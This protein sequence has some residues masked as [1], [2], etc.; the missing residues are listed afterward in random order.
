M[1]GL[2]TTEEIDIVENILAL[3]LKL[4]QKNS[5]SIV[6]MNQVSMMYQLR[7]ILFETKLAK[8]RFHMLA[9]HKEQLKCFLLFHIILEI[10]RRSSIF[11]QLQLQQ[12][13]L[14][15]R[16]VL[17]F[18]EQLKSGSCSNRLPKCLTHMKSEIR[19]QMS[20]CINSVKISAKSVLISLRCLIWKLR[21]GMY[22]NMKKF[23]IKG[24]VAV[25]L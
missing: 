7:L 12:L 18:K 23:G 5:L 1:S 13:C 6:S 3:T 11:L 14:V 20:Y 17:Y 19:K 8:T 10:F 15:I 2:V 24:L 9:T 25:L 22:L 21:P 16:L 4:I